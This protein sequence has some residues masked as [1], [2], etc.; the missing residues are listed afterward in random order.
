MPPYTKPVRTLTW[1]PDAPPAEQLRALTADAATPGILVV[2][3]R[4]AVAGGALPWESVEPWLRSRAV[5]VANVGG[6]L[7]GGALEVAT[8]RLLF[9]AGDP[10]EGARAFLE[11]RAPRFGGVDGD[12]SGQGG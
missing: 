7:A 6:R 3:F 12:G 4:D 5:T 1:T 2:R 8:F 11:R 10:E 9:A